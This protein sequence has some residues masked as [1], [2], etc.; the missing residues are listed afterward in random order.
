[1]TKIEITEKMIDNL[2]ELGANRWT[3]AGRDRLYIKKAAPELIGLRY[4]RYGTGNI[5]DAQINGEHISNSA[6]GRILSNLDKAFIDL[7]TG[8]IVLPLND[9]DGLE[10]KIEEALIEI[11]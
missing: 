11:Q 10:E 2:T 3:K 9:K 6:C 4:K 7:K 1:M 8:E 5:S